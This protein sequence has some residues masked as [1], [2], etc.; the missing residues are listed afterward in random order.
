MN[1]QI[2][3]NGNKNVTIRSI[4]EIF[5]YI[6]D[7]TI[8]LTPNRRLSAKLHHYFD[9]YQSGLCLKVWPTFKVLPIMSWVEK[10]WSEL[11]GCSL[12]AHPQLL[13]AIQENYL[14]ETVLLQSN[15]SILEINNTALLAKSSWDLLNHWQ[16]DI[17]LPIFDESEDSRIFKNWCLLFDK[18]INEKNFIAQSQLPSYISNHTNRLKSLPSKILLYGFTTLS[19]LYFNFI[20][21]LFQNDKIINITLKKNNKLT[22]RLS[23]K[24][25]ESEIRT[26]AQFAKTTHD[27]D[28][29]K[30]IACVFPDLEKNRDQI[31]RIFSEI[32][33]NDD[34]L[35]PDFQSLPFNISV[36]RKLSQI[37]IIS[38]AL[39]L[40]LIAKKKIQ[41]EDLLFILRTPFLA[42]AQ[43]EYFKRA[44]YHSV[45]K[46]FNL[47]AIDLPA[48][49]NEQSK[50]L[51]MNKYCPLLANKLTKFYLKLNNLNASHTFYE[52]GHIFNELLTI[53]GWPGERSLDSYEFQAANQWLML[54]SEIKTL[55]YVSEQVGFQKAFQVLLHAAHNKIFQP[56]TDEA[57]IQILGVLEA[58]CIP[59]DAMWVAGM[60]DASWPPTS[61]PN[62][63]IPKALQRQH[64]M[65]HA[66][67]EREFEFCKAISDHFKFCS[68]YTYFSHVEKNEQVE[69]KISPILIDLPEINIKDLNLAPYV[70]KFELIFESRI[71]QSIIDI[72]APPLKLDEA[73]SGGAN[74]IKQQ[75]LCPFKSFSEF[76]LHAFDHEQP[77]K[78]LSPKER[79]M[80]VH[81]VLESVWAH[82]K[83]HQGLLQTNEDDLALLL[84]NM[85]TNIFESH[86]SHHNIHARYFSLE[87]NRLIKLI[88]KWLD[89]EKKRPPFKVIDHEKKIK[90][91]LGQLEL[92]LRIDRI[93]QL[94]NQNYLIID[95]KTGSYI[96]SK[97][98]LSDRPDDPQLPL[99]LVF[100]SPQTV[101]IAFSQVTIKTCSF[102][103]LSQ[104]NLDIK[105]IKPISEETEITHT[106]EELRKTWLTNLNNLA[107]EFFQGY[108]A[109][110]PKNPKQTCNHC[111][112]GTLCRINEKRIDA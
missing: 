36:G 38:A 63:F 35:E 111:S 26:I 62:P 41:Y 32:F 27:E 48:L 109:V 85:I 90:I 18:T 44:Q 83:D 98:W 42:K 46:K 5:N 57:P 2:Q 59:F 65:P 71:L 84:S 77:T 25:K 17:N 51:S 22:R 3:S 33:S 37:P 68:F 93:D 21:E 9:T 12:K 28:K 55:D 104:Y 86:F 82:L 31:F 4:N 106:W 20:N 87:K 102:K 1:S 99:Y 16:L 96:T 73:R 39:R 29:H 64:N 97:S 11:L 66:T 19:P 110:E 88:N 47:Y 75:A 8:I 30:K 6:D 24:D 40:L 61:S 70:N 58:S 7:Q 108:A 78:G 23:L 112:L 92:N 74:I 103:G 43:S 56:K 10:L 100:S 81:M 67:P 105:G 95:Y 34:E 13:N 53:L 52:W 60:D 80:I 72:E 54:L 15:Q 107:S 50:N 69:F 101:S 45:I 76:R 14:W 94:E 79:G 91:Q 89:L 49:L